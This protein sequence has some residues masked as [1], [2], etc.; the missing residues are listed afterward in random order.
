MPDIPLAGKIDI[1]EL[2][3][4]VEELLRQEAQIR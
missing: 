4:A 2:T 3:G 1:Q